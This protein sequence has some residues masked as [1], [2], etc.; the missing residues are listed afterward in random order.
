MATWTTNTVCEWLDSI[1][2]EHDIADQFRSEEVDGQVLLEV[3]EEALKREFPH[4]SYGKRSNIIKER[5]AIKARDAETMSSGKQRRQAEWTEPERDTART[6]N[7]QQTRSQYEFQETSCELGTANISDTAFPGDGSLHCSEVC[8]TFDR[9]VQITHKYTHHDIL[10]CSE[11]QQQD[12]LEPIHRFILT[13]LSTKEGKFDLASETV[14]FACACLNDRTNGTLH[15][16]V[17]SGTS[18]KVK[19]GEILGTSLSGE[20]QDYEDY[21]RKTISSCFVPEQR[22]IV[23][24][25][26]RPLK[27]IEVIPTK[28]MQKF[29]VEIDVVPSYSLCE[30]DAFFVRM[31]TP[32][33]GIFAAQCLYRWRENQPTEIHG[34]DVVGFMKF[35]RKLAETRKERE[36]KYLRRMDSSDYSMLKDKLLNLLCIGEDGFIGDIYPILVISKPADNMDQSYM[37]ENMNFLHTIDWKVVFDFDANAV[38]C[39]FITSEDKLI[40]VCTTADDFY[41]RSSENRNDPEKLRCLEEDLRSSIPYPWIFVNGYSRTSTNTLD[42]YPWKKQKREGF[43]KA[44]DFFASEIPAGRAIVVFALLS[45]DWKVM[46]EAAEEFFSAFPDQWM[47]IAKDDSVSQ[48]WI[49]ELLR[50]NCIDNDSLK[51]RM[52]VGMPWEHVQEVV[53]QIRGPRRNGE[54]M[55]PT[56]TGAEVAMKQSKLNE[57]SDL[58]VLSAVQCENAE[59]LGTDKIDDYRR[60][61]EAAF[62]KGGEV[63]WWNFYF[64]DHVCVRKSGKKAKDHVR[65]FLDQRPDTGIGIGIGKVIVYH[66]PGAGGTTTCKHIL[67]DLKRTHRCAIVRTLSDQTHNQILNL[68]SFKDERPKAVVILLDN[69]DEEKSKV[70]MAMMEETAKQIAH[71]EAGTR[72]KLLCVFLV[73]RRHS[74]LSDSIIPL[75]TVS[76]KHVLDTKEKIWFKKKYEELEN[77]HQQDNGIDPKLLISFNILKENFGKEYIERTVK[78]LTADLTDEET[79]L[80]K[81][82]ALV[83]AFELGFHPLPTCAF[84]PLMVTMPFAPG[85]RRGRHAVSYRWETKLCDGVKILTNEV[86]TQGLGYIH[87]IRITSPLLSNVILS[88]LRKRPNEGEEPLSEVVTEFLNSDVFRQKSHASGELL[89]AVKAMMVNRPVLPSGQR[90]SK[91]SP[92]VQKVVKLES[93]RKAIEMLRLGYTLTNDPFVAQQVARFHMDEKDWANAETYAQYATQRMPEKSCLWDTYGRVFLNQV[94]EKYNGYVTSETQ[95]TVEEIVPVI[96]I[97]TRGIE[98]FRKKQQVSESERRMSSNKAGYVGEIEITVALLDCLNFVQVFSDRDVLHRFLVDEVF[99]PENARCLFDFNGQDYVSRLKQLQWDVRKVLV[100]LDDES[101]QLHDDSNELKRKQILDKKVDLHSYF[102]EGADAVDATLTNEE[103]CQRRRQ[104]LFQRDTDTIGGIFRLLDD[105]NAERNLCK[106]KGLLEENLRESSSPNAND[107]RTMISVNLALLHIRDKY[108][109][110]IKYEDMVDWSRTL[111]ELRHTVP[112]MSLEPY[113]F[114]TLFNWPRKNTRFHLM[115]RELNDALRQWKEA[116]YKKYPRQSNEEKPYR[117]RDNTKFFLANGSDMASI[118]SF[119]Q[120][121]RRKTKGDAF[122]RLPA[123]LRTLQRFSGR[124]S[125]DG[126]EIRV[127]LRC[128]CHDDITMSIPTSRPIGNRTMRNQTVFFVI[129]FSWFGPK[130]FDVSPNDPTENVPYMVMDHQNPRPAPCVRPKDTPKTDYVT[131]Q[132]FVKKLNEIGD[133]LRQLE[134]AHREK[135]TLTKEEVN[136]FSYHCYF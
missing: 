53:L 132:R 18:D 93:K 55:L 121:C 73:C 45:K 81:Y 4:T 59:I 22:D 49:E 44:V 118:T 77:N 76:L 15:F 46:L 6:R 63:C 2:M 106:I 43:K 71:D 96:D 26:V 75:G 104:A 7:N 113:L 40:K 129:G 127:N 54:C 110:I 85:P 119:D 126:D 24:A 5:N 27:F 114:Y 10:S 86:Y 38:V 41:S 94:V 120:L 29:V 115:P 88:H 116:Y 100:R 14:R 102:G 34:D 58:E 83:N 56:S 68:W 35:K 1:G 57:L 98:M 42:P 80:L 97:A 30:E 92:L 9:K 107:L 12:L 131:H 123:V 3:T 135:R 89:K 51:N 17:V 122:W 19:T 87:S 79:K 39:D 25:C 52:V 8:R 65:R 130:A 124:L 70:L 48:L 11:G 117:R 32:Q 67:W 99:V 91:F 72:H 90:E 109:N 105:R 23:Q 134:D 84:D 101:E 103:K 78:N 66:Q 69:E 82:V 31:P 108:L 37:K 112:F 60:K 20:Q 133:K 16:G 95:L 13:D 136:S 74:T 47:C 125:R 64:P 50:R 33:R 28:D 111:Y 61:V 21:M 128:E 36:H 62:Y